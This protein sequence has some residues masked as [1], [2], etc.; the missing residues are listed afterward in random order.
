[1]FA[2]SS[3]ARLSKVLEPKTRFPRAET[4]LPLEPGKHAKGPGFLRGTGVNEGFRPYDS[5][6]LLLEDSQKQIKLGHSRRN[7]CLNLLLYFG[8][9]QH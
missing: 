5:E 8:M 2:F 1:L 9:A 7:R 4:R 6:R 3:T